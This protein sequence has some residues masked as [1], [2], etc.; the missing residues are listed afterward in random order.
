MTNQNQAV[1][2]IRD[3]I[4]EA[5]RHTGRSAED[6]T[7]VAVSKTKPIEEIVAAYEAGIRHFGENRIEELE[8]KAQALRH[9]QDLKWHF[10]GHLQTRQSQSVAQYAHFFHAVDSIKIAQRLS[11]QLSEYKR[12]LPIFI[13]VNVSGEETKAGFSCKHW[14]TDAEQRQTLLSAIEEINLLPHLEILGLMTMAPFNAPEEELLDI[15]R[16]MA[17]LSKDIQESLPHIPA[18]ELSMGMSG[19]FEIAIR[20]GATV[21]RIGSAIFGGRG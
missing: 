7:L 4:A 16:N 13:Q 12:N 5:A 21:V 11:S 15:F 19:D 3:R 1:Q 14:K 18:R 9:L 6:I 17:E 8:E 20:E 2:T 10:I